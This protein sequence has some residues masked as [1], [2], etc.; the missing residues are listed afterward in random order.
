MRQ[1]NEAGQGWRVAPRLKKAVYHVGSS[2]ADIIPS[3]ESQDEA[4]GVG[5]L[6]LLERLLPVVPPDWPALTE[7]HPGDLFAELVEWHP[8]DYRQAG[9]LSRSLQ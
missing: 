8:R 5:N 7:P 2:D 9:L 6:Q 4:G 1:V 3:L